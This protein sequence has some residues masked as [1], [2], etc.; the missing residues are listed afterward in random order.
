MPYGRGETISSRFARENYLAACLLVI[1]GVR[2]SELLESKWSEHDLEKQRWHLPATRSKSGVGLEVPLP[3]QAIEWLNE[4]KW[5]SA[6]SEYVFPNR[7]SGKS[8]CI[9]KD[10]LNKAIANL[11]GIDSGKQQQPANVMGDLAYFTVH[12]LRR[13]CRSLLSSIGVSGHV[14]ER[15]LNHKLKGVEGIYDRHDYFEERKE[16]LQKLANSLDGVI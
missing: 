8:P 12:D 6:G 1:L 3:N 13:T 10:T 2:K 9:G 11:F 5:R 16:A 7:K 15:C 4:L 14:A